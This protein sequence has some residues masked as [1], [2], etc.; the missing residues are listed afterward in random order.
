MASGF[1]D[2][3]NEEWVWDPVDWKRNFN[4]IYYSNRII[5]DE[6]WNQN[7]KKGPRRD[8]AG[9]I[10]VRKT[11]RGPEFFLV[12]CYNNCFG[13]PKGKLEKGESFKDTAQREYFEETGSKINIED[14]LELKIYKRNNTLT[15]FVI[16]VPEDYDITTKP[17]ATHEITA[18]GW[19]N[20]Q[21]LKRIKLSGMTKE[22]FNLYKKSPHTK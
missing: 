12:Q 5:P 7:W 16:S 18:F 9:V 11:R 22:I 3:K 6:F 21:N 13:F 2:K 20:Y 14:S 15:F 8:S 1:F 17:L 19:V 4:G 10:L